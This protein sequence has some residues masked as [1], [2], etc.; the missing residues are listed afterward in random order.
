M[1]RSRTQKP[2][3]RLRQEEK[4]DTLIPD[5]EIAG[6]VR[7]L[8]EPVCESEDAELVHVEYQREASGRVLRIYIDKA[9][10]VK[11]EDCVKISRQL[12]DLLDVYLETGH[13]YSLEVSSPGPNRPL[14][15]ES[16]FEKFIG[17]EVKIKTC[18]FL[19]GQKNFKGV[20]LGLSEGEVK[21]TVNDK[22]VAIPFQEIQKAR[23]INFNGED[24]CLL[25]I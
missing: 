23:L 21:L 10:G 16:D 25:Q 20:L 8:A 12:G 3:K 6:K 15:K 13:P 14:G 9:G 17:C 24:T 7:R 11:L 4:R 22:K 2:K 5:A 18:R 1:L 19:D